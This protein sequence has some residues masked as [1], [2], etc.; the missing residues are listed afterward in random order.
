MSAGVELLNTVQVVGRALS[1]VSSHC[2][3]FPPNIDQSEAEP[4]YR[5]LSHWRPGLVAPTTKHISG[6]IQPAGSHHYLSC[7]A[8]L[9][10]WSLCPRVP[11]ATT[12]P[13]CTSTQPWPDLGWSMSGSLPWPPLD[14]RSSPLR[15]R[16]SGGH[17]GTSV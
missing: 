14:P 5:H 3:D 10:A 1:G 2:Q 11:P 13:P 7:S 12:S 4:S 17:R 16:A 8:C 6:V 9:L 15:S